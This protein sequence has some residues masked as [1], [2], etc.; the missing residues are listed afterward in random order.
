MGE[1]LPALL[2]DELEVEKEGPVMGSAILE[3]AGWAP[4][5]C[6]LLCLVRWVAVECTFF[7]GQDPE[8]WVP[9]PF[10]GPRLEDERELPRVSMLPSLGMPR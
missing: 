2:L 4:F 7:K 8:H 3:S 9:E 5:Y 6:L 10:P 1:T